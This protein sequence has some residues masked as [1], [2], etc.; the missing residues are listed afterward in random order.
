[1]SKKYLSICR[2]PL[3]FTMS[4]SQI[5]FTFNSYLFPIFFVES[6]PL[7]KCSFGM[8]PL[9]RHSVDRSPRAFHSSTHNVVRASCFEVLSASVESIKLFLDV[10]LC[11][12]GRWHLTEC[13][14]T[15][16]STSNNISR[17]NTNNYTTKTQPTNKLNNAHNHTMAEHSTRQIP[18]KKNSFQ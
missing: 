12:A 9:S 18:I 1:M 16:Y 3:Y 2:N 10:S 8:I 15:Q 5:R 13:A 6:V 11:S 4:R 14:A 17:P 7:A